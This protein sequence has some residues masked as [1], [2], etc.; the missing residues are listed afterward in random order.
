VRLLRF[1]AVEHVTIDLSKPKAQQTRETEIAFYASSHT[2]DEKSDA[3]KR[4][5]G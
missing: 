1:I 5:I 4:V 3:L 2:T